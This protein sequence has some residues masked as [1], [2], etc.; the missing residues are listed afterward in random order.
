MENENLETKNLTEKQLNET[1]GGTWIFGAIGMYLADVIIN[2]EAH[3]EAAS[4]GF[5]AGMEAAQ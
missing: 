2:Y 1:N 3:A 5:Q 4:S